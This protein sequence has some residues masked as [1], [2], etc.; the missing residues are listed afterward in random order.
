MSAKPNLKAVE[1]GGKGG[2][3][4]QPA[5]G[6]DGFRLSDVGNAQRL[7]A[8]HGGDLRFVHAWRRWFVWDGRRWA[9]DE[10]GEPVRRMV[11]TIRHLAA[12]A[13]ATDDPE[14]R[15]A[16]LKHALRS[17]QEPRVRAALSL[18]ESAAGVP[19]LTAELDGDP[20]LLNVENGTIDLRTGEL[21]E[22]S[23]DDLNTKLAPV[24]YDPAAR[25]PLF[26][27]FLERVL[28]DAELRRFVL[29]LL[30]YS[31]T[32]D[33]SEQ[34][35][36]IFYGT[37]SNGKSTLVETVRAMLGDYG[38]QAPASTFL[39][40]RGDTVRNDVARL[41]G[42]R[43]VAATETGEGRRLD[44]ALVKQLTGGDTI[45]ARFLHAEYFEFRPQFTPVIV[46]NHKPAVRG[47]DDAIWRRIRLVP[48]NVR[49]PDSDRD[50]H[51]QAKLRGELPGILAL[52]VKACLD[53]QQHGLPAAAAVTDAT[54]EYRS[55]SDL[56]GRFLDDC[57]VVGAGVKAKA[58]DLYN[59]L[60]YW[61]EA[62][63]EHRPTAKAFG[64]R[65]AERGFA[66][67]RS[68]TARWWAGVGI[69]HEPEGDA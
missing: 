57:C 30:G 13:A 48:F 62:N 66:A 64:S 12:A 34:V 42:A 46:T 53:W 8:R 22:H 17:E 44:E 23:R 31:L 49:I 55:D 2:P 41:R 24:V 20:F 67:T 10:T 4:E 38:Q 69:R 14:V 15:K 33:T 61:C 35:L 29:A 65:L 28:P 43:F 5:A 7:V 68:G 1:G 26:E 54:D 47:T 25:A 16:L 11:E 59:R 32:G 3:G 60:D 63:G 18:A 27:T 21:R 58:G 56:V 39:E 9:L 50:P 36:P 45:T 51:L 52:A 6:A 40:R 19:V 37:G